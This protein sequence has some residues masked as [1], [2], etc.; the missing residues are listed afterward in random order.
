[1]R[2]KEAPKI[3]NASVWTAVFVGVMAF[4]VSLSAYFFGFLDNQISADTDSPCKEGEVQ[5]AINNYPDPASLIDQS[6]SAYYID[7]SRDT[8]FRCSN[9]CISSDISTTVSERLN[10]LLQGTINGN[11][12]KI[13]QDSA[14]FNEAI[15][16]GEDA[17]IEAMTRG[18]II[19]QTKSSCE[20][21]PNSI[22][23]GKIETEGGEEVEQVQRGDENTQPEVDKDGIAI[24][25]ITGADKI[26]GAPVQ[27]EAPGSAVS[28]DD[29]DSSTDKSTTTADQVDE[30]M[31]QVKDY[32]DYY[33]PEKTSDLYKVETT[34]IGVRS[35]YK[36]IQ[37]KTKIDIITNKTQAVLDQCNAL[38]A[39]INRETPEAITNKKLLDSATTAKKVDTNNAWSNAGATASTK[40]PGVAERT[41]ESIGKF[42]DGIAIGNTNWN[43]RAY[44]YIGNRMD[45]AGSWVK[46]LFRK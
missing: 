14:S 4:S 40:Q 45:A 18:V 32:L 29:Q 25:D 9:V 37:D 11:K 39:R 23:Y 7:N 8:Y 20:G 26:A 17:K 1:M 15:K 3:V 42:F 35:D 33:K 5:V 28:K 24:R 41:G 34:K 38:I 6:H 22:S 46:G 19:P 13:F 21:M 16:K 10:K 31:K 30:C 36:R 43:E 27:L 44:R 12:I 2:T